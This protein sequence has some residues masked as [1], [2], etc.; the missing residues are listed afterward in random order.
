MKS[1]E[2]RE[3]PVKAGK[4]AGISAEKHGPNPNGQNGKPFSLYPHTLD[5]VVQKMLATPPP[6]YQPKAAKKSTAKEIAK[7]R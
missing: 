1:H 7:K 2:K 4:L 6:N 5:E 3:I